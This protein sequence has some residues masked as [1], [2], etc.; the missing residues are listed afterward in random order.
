MRYYD[1]P[2]KERE[3]VFV[4]LADLD[5]VKYGE[6]FKGRILLEVSTKFFTRVPSFIHHYYIYCFM[7]YLFIYDLLGLIQN[8]SNQV[9]TLK[10]VV[11]CNSIY[12]TGILANLVKKSQGEFEL[13]P[14]QSKLEVQYYNYILQYQFLY[15]QWYYN[16]PHNLT[17]FPFYQCRRNISNDSISRRIHGPSCRVL[18]A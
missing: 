14:G 7:T 2:S 5:K 10:A 6:V 16:H 1:Y 17:Y 3:D 4:E 9:R 18:Y 13:Q 8:R 12:Y 11:S 15:Y